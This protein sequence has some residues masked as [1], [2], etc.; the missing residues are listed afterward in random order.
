[1]AATI[2][3]GCMMTKDQ[4]ETVLR[5]L[6]ALR[7]NRRRLVGGAAVGALVAP[8]IGAVAPRN[9]AAAP[10]ATIRAQGDPRTLVLLDNV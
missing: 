1:M 2:E 9:V 8:T 5:N 4:N 6:N 7:L 10:R 3:R